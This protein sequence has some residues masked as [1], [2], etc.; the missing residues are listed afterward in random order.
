MTGC[1]SGA[2]R[3]RV[4]VH[5]VVVDGETCERCGSTWEAAE[6]AVAEVAAELAAIGVA[7]DLVELPLPADAVAESNRVYVAG[8]PAEEWLGGSVTSTDCPSCGEMLG[9]PT[10]CQAYEIGGVRSDALATEDIARAI[11]QAAEVIPTVPRCC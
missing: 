7:V 1:C 11:R 3:I 5:R 6:A 10:C 9:E 8:R 2:A 4:E